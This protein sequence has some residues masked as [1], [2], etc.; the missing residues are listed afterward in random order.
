MSFSGNALKVTD[1]T[2]TPTTAIFQFTPV[3]T[4]VWITF[5]FQAPASLGTYLAT[6]R[7]SEVL[8][9]VVG[10]TEGQNNAF[11]VADIAGTGSDFHLVDWGPNN[12]LGAWSADTAYL[13]E[14][15]YH[16]GV[17]VDYY[18]DGVLKLSK[19]DSG[20]AD[21]TISGVKYGLWFGSGDP[22][23]TYLLDNFKL[24]SSR[25][26]SD[27]FLD[28]FESGIPTTPPYQASPENPGG[29]SFEITTDFA[30]LLASVGLHLSAQF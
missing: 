8:V 2:A 7:D 20:S 5:D 3:K 22:N 27:F 17:Q 19:D 18:V 4:D 15:H 11:A 14:M 13:I 30:P 10:L 28:D 6:N 24:G 23:Q 9:G 26:A 29:N 12:D 16:V 25:A 21:Q 1:R